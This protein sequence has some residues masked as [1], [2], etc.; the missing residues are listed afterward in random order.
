[1]DLVP[2]VR[3]RFRLFTTEKKSNL[4]QEQYIHCFNNI[5]NIDF[6]NDFKLRVLVQ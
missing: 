4:E 5:F 6:E 3:F 1:M 2:Q